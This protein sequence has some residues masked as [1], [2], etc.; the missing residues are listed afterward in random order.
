MLFSLKYLLLQTTTENKK[1]RIMVVGSLSDLE[2]W[3]GGVPDRSLLDAA[4]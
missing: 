3:S 2:Y 4:Y 1:N